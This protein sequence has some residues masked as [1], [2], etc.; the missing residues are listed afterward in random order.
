MY[1][2]L[3]RETVDFSTPS[4]SSKFPRRPNENKSHFDSAR[5]LANGPNPRDPE[6]I[7]N[8]GI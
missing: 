5:H 3:S 2:R 1:A 6:K 7:L 8:S 4:T